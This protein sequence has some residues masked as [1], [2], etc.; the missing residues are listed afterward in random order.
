MTGVRLALCAARAIADDGGKPP[1]WLHLLPSGEIKSRDGRGPYRVADVA[2]V[3]ANSLC[4][5]GGKLVLDENHSTDLLAPKGG[6]APARGWIVALQARSDGIWG[7]VNWTEAATNRRIWKEYQ[8][9]S[10]VISHRQDGMIE[11]VL[12]ASLVNLPNIVGLTSLHI[13]MAEEI[14]AQYDADD[15]KSPREMDE[16]DQAIAVYLGIDAKRFAELLAGSNEFREQ[17]NPMRRQFIADG[18]KL[19]DEKDIP[20]GVADQ[21]VIAKMGLDPAAYRANLA[22]EGLRTSLHRMNGLD[23]AERCIVT[24]IGAFFRN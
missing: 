12:R 6:E 18:V 11:A 3:I 23:E 16:V 21:T 13:A 9:V 4:Q 5:T 2:K 19:V 8:G 22:K 1:E 17:I 10:P 14:A 24:I 15:Y 7:R 20:L